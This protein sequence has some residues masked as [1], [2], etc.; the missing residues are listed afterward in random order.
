MV[1]LGWVLGVIVLLNVIGFIV[2]KVFFKDELKTIEPYGEM[3]DVDGSKM[4]IYSLGSG[5]E[6][7]VLLPGWGV[8]LPSADFGPLMR[9]LSEKYTVVT[10]EYFGVGFSDEVDT[11]R[12]NANYTN[13]I[14][15][16]LEKAG[17]NP[18]YILMPHSASGIY[19]E[20]Y[21]TKYPEEVSSIIML[22][23][24]STARVEK[25][26]S[27][28]QYIYSLAKL[29]QATGSTRLLLKLV[30]DQNSLQ[31]GY[32]LKEKNDYK[33]FACHSIND[34][35]IRQSTEL[36]E[37]IKELKPLPFP[38]HIRVLKII[39]KQT[40]AAMAKKDKDDGMGYQ[41]EHLN[42]LG[43][44]VSY[45]VLDTTH[46]PYHNKVEEISNLTDEFLKGT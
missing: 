42:R 44:N 17:F 14:R 38:D 27:Y 29:Q 25:I 12:T 41:N 31:N 46:F 30:P 23:T 20:Y 39:S 6:T 4:H 13:E 37:N 43:E 7:I 16:A 18:P 45:R 34:T 8:A 32:T 11:P 19:S 33:K 36:I 15:T 3:V 21:A 5:K 24:T 9:K 10:V 2:N 35:I 26:P 1:I 40:I 28:V 22:D